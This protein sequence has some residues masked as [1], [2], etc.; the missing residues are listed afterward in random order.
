MEKVA[1]RASKLIDA[2]D[3][4]GI[5]WKETVGSGLTCCGSL[6]PMTHFRRGLIAVKF[7]GIEVLRVRGGGGHLGPTLSECR[8][9]LMTAAMP[10]AICGE[11][12]H[13][14]PLKEQALSGGTSSQDTFCTHTQ[15]RCGQ[16]T[17]LPHAVLIWSDAGA[18]LAR[19]CGPLV[20]GI[21]VAQ[22]VTSTKSAHL[23]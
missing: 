8:S 3:W 20:P 5:A 9:S 12:L 7:A 4:S 21:S 1:Y 18:A 22:G 2:P 6:L 16:P 13:W 15:G 11:V 14:V 19:P 17:V 23:G 10:R